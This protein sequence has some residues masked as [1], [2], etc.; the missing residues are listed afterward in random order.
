MTVV[1]RKKLILCPFCQ[2]L[3]RLERLHSVIGKRYSAAHCGY[4]IYVIER[5]TQFI[6][7]VLR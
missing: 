7:E 6:K 5:G 3:I 4:D 1:K 2:K